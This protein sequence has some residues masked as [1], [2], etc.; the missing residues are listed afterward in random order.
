MATRGAGA[1][2]PGFPARTRR[3]SR[4]RGASVAPA[5][6]AC[7]PPGLHKQRLLHDTRAVP[8]GARPRRARR[9]RERPPVQGLAGGLRAHARAGD[10]SAA[11][12][13]VGQG[14]PLSTH[15]SEPRPGLPGREPLKQKLKQKFQLSPRTTRAVQRG[16]CLL[17]ARALAPLLPSW[18][19]AQ[20]AA[21]HV[22]WRGSAS[23]AHCRTGPAARRV[24]LACWPL[25]MHVLQVA[26][27]AGVP[28]CAVCCAPLHN[29]SP[30]PF[31]PP[32]STPP[33]PRHSLAVWLQWAPPPCVSSPNAARD[34]GLGPRRPRRACARAWGRRR[35]RR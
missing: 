35:R 18:S 26:L 24:R 21:R 11:P 12:L 34:D 23:S 27:E 9:P 25:R 32:P 29:L 17:R 8:G 3:A 20:R 14:V 19:T 15:R 10:A 31:L 16:L 30:P 6:L 22:P 28:H 33:F 2:R 7:P 13:R 4:V 5:S 1:P